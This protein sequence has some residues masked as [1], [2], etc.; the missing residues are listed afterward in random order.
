MP[1]LS[2]R[3]I[4]IVRHLVESAP[5]K[6]VGG[7]QNA[8]AAASGDSV[9]AGVRR[10]VESEVADRR[11]RNAVLSPIAPLCVAGAVEQGHISFPPRVMALI[12]R[13]LKDSC[14][15]E[16]LKAER[17]LADY[18][19]DETSTEPFDLLVTAA[20]D[21]LR[22][23]EQR[24]FAAAADLADASREGGAELLLS[25]LALSPII[26][27]AILRL[28]DWIS[29]TTEERA[30]AAR[31]AYKDAVAI[32]DDAGPRF[33]EML[34]AQLAEPWTILRIVS[35]VMD[36]PTEQYLAASEFSVFAEQLMDEIDK[37]LTKVA[38]LDL[39][40]GPEAGRG[41]GAVVELI[42][43]QIAEIE[44][45]I[46]LGKEGG[47]GGRVQKQKKALA[48]VVE[49][50]LR[51]SDKVIGLALPS[52]KVRV[53]RVMKSLPRLTGA[54][55]EKAVT[56][57]TTLLT[58]IEAVRSSANY[59]GFASTRA[60]V[61]ETVGETIDDYVEEALSLL[62]DGEVP[63]L[64]E[65][66]VFLGVAADFSTLLRDPRTGDVIRRRATAA[67]AVAKPAAA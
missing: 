3:K 55:D 49:G 48:A 45:S 56:R 10:L 16:V 50:R 24:D 7:L 6:I 61:V 66:R 34:A 5:D 4:E 31:L 65:A 29:R 26:R 8:L 14:P 25:C 64:E 63:D 12:W 33:F 60:K 54:P 9:L 42:T 2:D 30:A 44:N 62:R 18:R 23:R 47:W 53:A 13:G 22:E 38:Q 40:G 39:S 28:P 21:G 27:D 36:H 37:N 57:A 59:G 15:T 32:S 46:Q 51:E 52:H 1:G 20:A 11:L 17:T 19:A 41:A 43:L 58:F 35:A 67:L